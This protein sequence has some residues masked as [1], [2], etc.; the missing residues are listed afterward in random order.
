MVSNKT[1]G[2]QV[3]NHEECM[4]SIL[5]LNVRMVQQLQQRKF[6]PGSF[7]GRWPKS[8]SIRMYK[9]RVPMD[10]CQCTKVI[11]F[12]CGL[13]NHVKLGLSTGMLDKWCQD[14]FQNCQ[15][16]QTSPLV[17]KA[18]KSRDSGCEGVPGVWMFFWRKE[19]SKNKNWLALETWNHIWKIFPN[20]SKYF[21]HPMF[22]HVDAS[23]G[24]MLPFWRPW[25]PGTQICSL[26][27]VFD[28]FFFFKHVAQ[29]LIDF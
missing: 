25:I 2:K 22:H 4:L 6:G 5:R 7:W 14:P 17:L 13:Q 8:L 11:F 3:E 19:C 18:G 1:T 16:E 9:N 10:Q 24:H 20:T 27:E 28:V 23:H 29:V 21:S 26:L 15:K 12:G